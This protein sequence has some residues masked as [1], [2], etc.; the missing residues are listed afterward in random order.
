MSV[1]LSQ[2]VGASL[3]LRVS[4]WHSWLDVLSSLQ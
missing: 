1:R 3:G 2:I 4:S